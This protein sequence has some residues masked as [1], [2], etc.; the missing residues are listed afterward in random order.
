MQ[1]HVSTADGSPIYLQIA[2]QIK[3]LAAAGR[4]APDEQL[5]S[6]R[7]L[8]EQLLVNPNTVQKAYRQL[9]SEG[10]VVTKRGAGVF[11]A[12]GVSPLARRE[13]LRILSERIDVLLAEAAQMGVEKE[14]LMELLEKR[15]RKLEE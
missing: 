8:A 11:L 3:Y 4:I 6:V 10:V 9:E 7:K 15:R 1:L 14:E 2:S 13:Q 12:D 5:P